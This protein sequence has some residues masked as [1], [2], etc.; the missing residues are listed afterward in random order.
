MYKVDLSEVEAAAK[1]LE[2][3]ALCSPLGL[4]ETQSRKYGASVYFK[5]EDLQQVRSYKI[6]GAYNKISTIPSADLQKGVVCASAG[7]HAQGVAYSC[8]RKKVKGMI[9][10]PTPTPKQK[11]AQVKMFGGDYVEVIL[12]GDT[13]DDASQQARNYCKA[14]AMIFVHPF[15]DEKVIEGQATIGLE[16]LA[17]SKVGIDYLFLPVGGGG[18]A[19]GVSS[20][21]KALS[22]KT[23]IIGVEPEG[24]PSMSTSLANGVNTTL[25]E[26]EKF[27][28]G[29][30]VKRVGDL[31]FH[32]CKKNLN[33]MA[34]V[35]EGKICQTILDMYNQDAIVVEPAGAMTVA[36]LDDYS[37]EIR[38][39]NV[40]CLVSGSNNDITRT[41][42]IKERALLHAGVKHY[43][44][45]RFPQRAGA[46]RDFIDKVLGP[47]DD[48]THFEYS[49]KQS[50]EN[51][52][53]VVG[54]ELGS[55][56]E[57]NALIER[58]KAFKFYG[59]YLNDKP[60][61]FQFL[62]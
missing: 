5:R 62:V 48:I 42:E 57:L 2:N 50:R 40:V 25:D 18:V 45:V 11:I 4:N 14:N 49:K 53:A 29:A 46:L 1:R 56:G 16:I 7:N 36:A 27:V 30:S 9:F 37:E 20:V 35:H 47:N 54:I 28:D 22:P 39:K 3:V 60:D 13:F 31:N 55:S 10:M 17:Q 38:G 21:F 12:V 15:D 43:F 58:M 52:P 51:A 19:S 8:A 41:E 6:R 61:L 32:I 59:E 33:Q 24:A 23:K 26:V 44:V 34:T